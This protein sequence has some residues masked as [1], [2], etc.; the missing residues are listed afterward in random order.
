MSFGKRIVYREVI[1]GVEHR[2]PPVQYFA[3][4]GMK[5]K[6][7]EEF[8]FWHAGEVSRFTADPSLTYVVEDVLLDYCRYALYMWILFHL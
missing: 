8:M 6:N 3:P 5:E 1:D 2:F 7:H 4:G